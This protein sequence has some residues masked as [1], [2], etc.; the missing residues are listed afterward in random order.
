[1]CVGVLV[2][3]S[4]S[5]SASASVCGKGRPLLRA[6]LCT[7]GATGS[8][9]ESVSNCTRPCTAAVTRKRM[10]PYTPMRRDPMSFFR[11]LD[12]EKPVCQRTHTHTH[13]SSSFCAAPLITHRTAD[14]GAAAA[15][16][17][18]SLHIVG[19]AHA[20]RFTALAAIRCSRAHAAFAAHSAAR[21]TTGARCTRQERGTARMKTI[22]VESV[23]P[24]A[25]IYLSQLLRCPY[26]VCAQFAL[27]HAPYMGAARIQEKPLSIPFDQLKFEV[28]LLSIVFATM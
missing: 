6:L 2:C 12:H 19:A 28:Q 1:M 13:T 21:R 7:R 20:L 23:H 24:A 26:S 22:R 3:V 5:V 4:V 17:N 18:T 11:L 8:V 14:R 15:E 10:Q 16:A 27:C 25:Q 9:T